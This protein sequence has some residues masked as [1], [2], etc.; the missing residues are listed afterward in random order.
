VQTRTLT[1]EARRRL[2]EA[3]ITFH[4]YGGRSWGGRMI[5]ADIP[6]EGRHVRRRG[7][8]GDYDT[9]LT[10]ADDEQGRVR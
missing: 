3:P 4:V 1:P 5:V 8:D 9:N 2:V 10:S 7:T 6:R